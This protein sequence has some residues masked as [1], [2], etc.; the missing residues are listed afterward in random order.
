M[1]KYGNIICLDKTFC[2]IIM[3]INNEILKVLEN[4]VA[5]TKDELG[6][7]HQKN[8]E[9]A[10]KYKVSYVY[11][12]P[13][14]FMHCCMKV[15][16][17]KFRRVM[18]WQQ[19]ILDQVADLKLKLA[20]KDSESDAVIAR[21]RA[22]QQEADT[23]TSRMNEMLKRM[24][25]ESEKSALAVQKAIQSSVRLCVVAPTVNVH[26]ADKKMKFRSK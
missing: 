16:I 13:R 2:H 20:A 21:C 3:Y 17:V 1:L 18:N 22:L 14:G 7:V 8:S 24:T 15:N 9:W 25:A 6:A 19:V 23:A 26:V 5:A 4:M 11:V 12:L 10:E